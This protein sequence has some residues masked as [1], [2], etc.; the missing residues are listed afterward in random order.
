MNELITNIVFSGGGVKGYSYIGVIKAL[1]EQN[2]LSNI[3][4]IAG[5]SIG[6]LFAFLIILKYTFNELN[7]LCFNIDLEQINNVSSDNILNF[8]YLMGIDDGSKCERILKI[9]LKAKTN[10]TDIT[11]KQ[12]YDFNNINLTINSTRINDR[13]NI[14]YNHL[15][16]PDFSVIK[17][18][19]MSISIPFIYTPVLYDNNYY[20]DGGVTNNFLIDLFK[21]NIENTLG[22]LIKDP[23]NNKI[24][25]IY[26]YIGNV[27]YSL[28]ET[29]K[30]Q[31]YSKYNIVLLESEINSININI[32]EKTKQ[33]LIDEG[34]KNTINYLNNNT[35]KK[36]MYIDKTTQTDS[37]LI[38]TST[39]TE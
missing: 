4:N 37:S 23:D 39:Q 17:A 6:S 38:D 34:Y 1:E 25:D 15:N 27:F 36:N 11:F 22:F 33:L 7:E 8:I 5:T 3:K 2:I 35:L 20:V 28:I 14:I 32:D 31:M 16:T 26:E 21:N 30:E 19:R 29:D 10:V 12:L 13:K 18:I 9:L 24:E